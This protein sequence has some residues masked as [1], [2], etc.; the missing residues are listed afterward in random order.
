[1]FLNVLVYTVI[2]FL[3]K[4]KEKK[5]YSFDKRRSVA[6]PKGANVL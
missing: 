5:P 2:V 1:M 3:L 4:K 6:D